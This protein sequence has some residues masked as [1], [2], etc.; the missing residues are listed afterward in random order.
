MILEQAVISVREVRGELE[1]R[2]D[3]TI[4]NQFKNVH[5]DFFSDPSTVELTFIRD[6]YSNT[7]FEQNLTKKKIISGG[8]FADP[9]IIAKA[10]VISGTVVTEEVYK[11]HAAKIPNICET[12]LID[13]INMEGFLKREGWKF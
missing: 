5:A 13:C 1:D 10:K 9:F 6:I 2:F 8:Y 4:I 12:F 3:K 11:E 7:H